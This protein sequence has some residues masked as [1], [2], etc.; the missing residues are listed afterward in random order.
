MTDNVL[1]PKP[2]RPQGTEKP[3]L[4]KPE[5][6]SSIPNTPNAIKRGRQEAQKLIEERLQPIKNQ[7]Q[8]Q[9]KTKILGLVE[10]IDDN[11]KAQRSLELYKHLHIPTSIAVENDQYIQRTE[12]SS[13]DCIGHQLASLQSNPNDIQNLTTIELYIQECI[14]LQHFINRVLLLSRLILNE[15]LA[16]Y[17]SSN[18]LLKVDDKIVDV[19]ESMQKK[20]VPF[21]AKFLVNSLGFQRVSRNVVP[22]LFK[23][24]AI[25]ENFNFDDY[26][27][28]TEY[29]FE[30]ESQVS[31]SITQEPN[32]LFV[33]STPQ[34]SIADT[35]VKVDLVVFEKNQEVPPE[36]LERIKELVQRITFYCFSDSLIRSYDVSRGME[37][38]EEYVS[39]KRQ[40]R[41]EYL[42]KQIQLHK[43][44]LDYNQED[45][46]P[47][48]HK[49][50]NL[51]SLN[52]VNN[53]SIKM[54]RLQNRLASL[55]K[56]KMRIM[57]VYDQFSGEL[58]VLQA[59][60]YQGFRENLATKLPT[61]VAP[62]KQLKMYSHGN[63][64]DY[65]DDIIQDYLNLEI[66]IAG[67]PKVLTDAIETMSSELTL[68]LYTHN[69][70]VRKLQIKSNLNSLQ[71]RKEMQNGIY[72]GV[73]SNLNKHEKQ[74][75]P[76]VWSIAL[77]RADPDIIF[78]NER[79]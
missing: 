72:T 70:S 14:K 28:N 15:D 16:P 47:V 57:R 23:S 46:Y 24:Y 45:I 51:R 39:Q 25:D 56:N 65:S 63:E 69:I 74:D 38:F 77:G 18:N 36:D 64:D 7:L 4:N 49:L 32:V 68:L 19:V 27:E 20:F 34:F 75:I 26:N 10:S 8:S 30:V 9:I 40:T 22:Y 2:I 59:P 58:E 76:D 42:S 55:R 13:L 67:N 61:K 52:G 5:F 48:V 31:K 6:I 41:R 29:G 73:I 1:R 54:R 43:S 53:E 44:H 33:I 17:Q 78:S 12:V 66:D 11:S 71:T 37:L 3:K 79:S 35:K 62:R 60:D 50:I 21:K